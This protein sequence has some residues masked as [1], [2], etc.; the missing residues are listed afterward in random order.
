MI[1]KSEKELEYIPINNFEYI[2]DEREILWLL[3][4]VNDKD[5]ETSKTVILYK[6]RLYNIIATNCDFDHFIMWNNIFKTKLLCEIIYL[7]LNY[8][9]KNLGFLEIEKCVVKSGIK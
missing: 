6:N 8:Y 1:K 2:C 7:K 9:G 4:I 3:E 5:S